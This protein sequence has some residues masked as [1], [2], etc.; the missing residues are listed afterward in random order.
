KEGA[1][2]A[3]LCGRMDSFG[4]AHGAVNT[5][6][7][8]AEQVGRMSFWAKQGF[9]DNSTFDAAA[10]FERYPWNAWLKPFLRDIPARPYVRIESN[11][12]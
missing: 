4:I 8:T 6:V 12:D 3:T 1:S 5:K 10:F 11:R 2:D 7:A 9:S